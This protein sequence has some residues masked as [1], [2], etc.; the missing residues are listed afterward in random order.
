MSATT[1]DLLGRLEQYEQE[2]GESL[3]QLEKNMINLCESLHQLEKDMINLFILE[4]HITNSVEIAKLT[5]LASEGRV[6]AE[7]FHNLGFKLAKKHLLDPDGTNYYLD[8]FAHLTD[9]ADNFGYRS[10]VIATVDEAIA[11]CEANVQFS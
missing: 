6:T 8:Q 10:I 9:L 11:W 2:L 4:N 7:K 3:H 5:S 1:L